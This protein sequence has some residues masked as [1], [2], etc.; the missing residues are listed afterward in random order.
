MD[1]IVAAGF[2]TL[3][4]F[5]ALA[6]AFG[7]LSLVLYGLPHL[8]GQD[9]PREPAAA[10]AIPHGDGDGAHVLAPAA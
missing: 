4:L 7:V 8:P 6:G 1:L 9:I 5:L 10:H 3:S 2:A